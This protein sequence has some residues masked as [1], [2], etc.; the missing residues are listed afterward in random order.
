MAGSM[1]YVSGSSLRT[2]VVRAKHI[3][4]NLSACLQPPP[5]LCW[6]FCSSPLI[7]RTFWNFP[8]YHNHC[9]WTLELYANTE[10]PLQTLKNLCQQFQ[11]CLFLYNFTSFY[12]L[13]YFL[14]SQFMN[15][16]FQNMFR[17]LYWISDKNKFHVCF[18]LKQ[19]YMFDLYDIPS[20]PDLKWLGLVSSF[21]GLCKKVFSRSHTSES[22]FSPFSGW[23]HTVGCSLVLGHS[24]DLGSQDHSQFSTYL[25]FSSQDSG[26]MLCDKH[27]SSM[28]RA[29]EHLSF[30]WVFLSVLCGLCLSALCDRTFHV[31]FSCFLKGLKGFACQE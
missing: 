3:C 2:L 17:T 9:M 20:V 25:V 21:L 5:L 12:L 15:N 24:R 19:M 31:L 13:S 23:W 11:S 6:H 7:P 28:E 26:G 8:S 30:R 1:W 10:V 4:A 29:K 16:N 22:E 18:H 14:P 27:I